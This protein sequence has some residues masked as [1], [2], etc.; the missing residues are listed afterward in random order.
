MDTWAFPTYN[1]PEHCTVSN[2]RQGTNSISRVNVSI[3][4]NHNNPLEQSRG[5]N[6]MC[7]YTPQGHTG[8][9]KALNIHA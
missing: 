8:E 6:V 7:P 3:M 2:C 9:G 4:Y 1:I 5:D